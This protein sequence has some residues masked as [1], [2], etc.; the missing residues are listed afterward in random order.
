M[1]KPDERKESMMKSGENKGLV[2][3]AMA[4]PEDESPEDGYNDATDTATDEKPADSGQVTDDV[5]ERLLVA[6]VRVMRTPQGKQ[7][8]MDAAQSPDP[9]DAITRL[10]ASIVLGIDEKT[11][12]SVPDEALG[13]AAQQVAQMIAGLLSGE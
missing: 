7:E 6:A 2:G 10:S 13:A 12:Q 8:L 1:L 11:G 5:V 9:R 4:M 3:S